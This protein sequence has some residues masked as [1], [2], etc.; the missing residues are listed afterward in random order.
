M[1][2]LIDTHILLWSLFEPDKLK[3]TTKTTLLDQSKQI[4]VST[5]SFWEI[6][7]KYSL[8]KLE[9]TGDVVPEDLIDSCIKSG[10]DI[11]ELDPRTVL[12]YY[13]LPKTDHKDPFD[14][15]LIWQAIQNDH[16]IVSQ[17]RLFKRYHPHGLRTF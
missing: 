16:I 11:L 1:A 2:Y 15:L 14:R 3:P 4:L 5:V 9:F 13:R 17:D 10:Y 12:T 7:L 6:S 8:G